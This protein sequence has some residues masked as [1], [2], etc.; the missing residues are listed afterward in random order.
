M[1]L[2]LSIRHHH[3]VSRRRRGP[4]APMP[5]TAGPIGNITG[6]EKQYRVVSKPSNSQTMASRVS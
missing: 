6:P 4:A 1:C 5:A 2:T 3:Q